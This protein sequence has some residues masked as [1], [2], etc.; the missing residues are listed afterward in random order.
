MKAG[1]IAVF[2][3]FVNRVAPTGQI[4]YQGAIYYKPAAPLGQYLKLFTPFT[5]YYHLAKT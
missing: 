1:T 5:F 3:I 2:Q 4:K